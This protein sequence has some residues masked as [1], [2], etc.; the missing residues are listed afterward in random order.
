MK[1]HVTP[2]KQN[3]HLSGYKFRQWIYF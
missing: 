2:L 3:K 1:M